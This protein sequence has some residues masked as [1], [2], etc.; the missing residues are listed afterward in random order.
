[1]DKKVLFT[2]VEIYTAPED[3][4]ADKFFGFIEEIVSSL[5]HELTAE[6]ENFK[7]K[8]QTQF[9]PNR[10]P[11]YQIHLNGLGNTRTREKVIGILRRTSSIF[12]RQNESTVQVTFNVQNQQ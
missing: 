10:S 2:G 8:L 7:F 11:K 9:Y 1:M 12:T 3:I 4:P 5:E 6:D